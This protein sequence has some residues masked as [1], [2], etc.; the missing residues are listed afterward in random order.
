MFD[1][2]AYENMKVVINGYF[3]DM[4]LEGKI[5]IIDRNDIVNL[6]KLSR[7]YSVQFQ[8]KDSCEEYLATFCLKADLE[9]LTAELLNLKSVPNR[10]GSLVELEFVVY[11]PNEPIYFN[12]IH[13]Q[14]QQIWGEKRTI[15]QQVHFNPFA[16]THV[17]ENRIT[18]DFNRIIIEEQ[19]DDLLVI[20][21]Y[22]IE[23][24]TWLENE[25]H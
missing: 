18:I 13:D 4:D 5:S 1:P 9:N 21:N 14:L 17:I 11:H 22:M 16:N 23:T 19:I 25:I 2:T 24:L 3:Y 7:E 10:I 12:K 8:L 20:G 15:Q 6:A